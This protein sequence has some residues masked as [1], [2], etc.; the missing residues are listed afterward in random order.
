M[1]LNKHYLLMRMI[2]RVRFEEI[3]RPAAY[4]RQATVKLIFKLRNTIRFQKINLKRY[5]NLN[6]SYFKP[7]FF[8]GL[9]VLAEEGA[10]LT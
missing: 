8:A 7:L 10:G 5:S 6:C 4:G 3:Y 1:P 2:R 9:S